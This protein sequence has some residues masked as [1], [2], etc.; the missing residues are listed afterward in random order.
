MPLLGRN[1]ENTYIC[2]QCMAV[3]GVRILASGRMLNVLNRSLHLLLQVCPKTAGNISFT[4][5][6]KESISVRKESLS[7]SVSSCKPCANNCT[8]YENNITHKM[9]YPAKQQRHACVPSSRLI[10]FL[11]ICLM[12][13]GI[14]CDRL[15]DQP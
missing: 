8:L 5:R 11:F 1:H 4:V 9:K 12:E 3:M 2:P 15:C 14:F 7:M 6:N 10:S 13:M